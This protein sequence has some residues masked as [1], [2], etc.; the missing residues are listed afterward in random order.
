MV[1]TAFKTGVAV[2]E[3][4][5]VCP[6][7][8]D[9][10]GVAVGSGELAEQAARLTSVRSSRKNNPIDLCAM[11]RK[12]IFQDIFKPLKRKPPNCSTAGKKIKSCAS[13]VNKGIMGAHFEIVQRNT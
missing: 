7:V 1:S 9:G 10:S 11:P 2:R 4:R 5:G 12:S 6:A 8:D 13:L 3:G